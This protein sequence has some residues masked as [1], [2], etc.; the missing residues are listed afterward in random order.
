LVIAQ[1]FHAVPGPASKRELGRVLGHDHKAAK[2]CRLQG[3]PK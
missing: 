1:M 3:I 2:A